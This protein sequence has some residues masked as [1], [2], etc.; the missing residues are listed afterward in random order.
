MGFGALRVINDDIVEPSKGFSTHPH[1][2]MEIVSIPLQGTLRHKD[3]MGNLHV[4]QAG[5]VQIMSAGTGITHSEYN[6]SGRED[7]RFLQIWVLPKE[8]D[9]TPRYD[10][11]RFDAAQRKNKFQLLVSPDGVEGSMWMNQDGYF[12]MMDLEVNRLTSYQLH[13]KNNGVYLFLISGS[14]SVEGEELCQRDG[15]EISGVDRIDMEA[16]EPVELLCME[17]PL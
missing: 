1:E 13:N 9:I 11:I 3:S 5:E 12:S 17:V 15:A 6:D 2:N 16:V 8:S 10:Q 14:L 4:I 7:V